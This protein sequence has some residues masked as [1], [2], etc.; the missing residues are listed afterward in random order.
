MAMK[1]LATTMAA[2]AAAAFSSAQITALDGGAHRYARDGEIGLSVR[3]EVDAATARARRWLAATQLESGAWASTNACG[4]TALA[5]LALQNGGPDFADSAARAIAWLKA[6]P[7]DELAQTPGEEAAWRELALE[8][9]KC[10][11]G[12]EPD[13]AALARALARALTTFAARH[14]PDGIAG[15]CAMALAENGDRPHSK[16][17][18]HALASELA[19][20]W[21]ESGVPCDAACGVGRTL[22]FAAHFINTSADGILSAESDGKAV[23][24]PW[25][26]D[27]AGALVSGQRVDP[28]H[29]GTAFWRG[30]AAARAADWAAEP[31][32]ET[33][34]AILCLDEL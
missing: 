26:E 8:S 13:E 11:D 15:R 30:S 1:L 18:Q 32:P 25:R 14:T 23:R 5:A 27:A 31:V 20:K 16:E 6:I 21:R 2:I 9:A 19:I 22:F 29:H 28:K 12:I 7:E 4:A 24:V 33:A 34:F 17:V 3:N 10:A